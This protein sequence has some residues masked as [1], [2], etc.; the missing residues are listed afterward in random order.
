MCFILQKLET[1]RKLAS[2]FHKKNP[3][4]S[5]FR[6]FFFGSTRFFFQP[7]SSSSSCPG[8]SSRLDDFSMTHL[9]RLGRS[10]ATLGAAEETSG[11]GVHW[12]NPTALMSSRHFQMHHPSLGGFK[13][14]FF[15]SIPGDDFQVDSYFFQKP[16]T[17]SSK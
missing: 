7:T 4:L 17:R 9:A 16:P 10:M 13:D 8:P 14:F 5:H 3:G 15:S 11:E 1:N 12:R 6:P 2:Q